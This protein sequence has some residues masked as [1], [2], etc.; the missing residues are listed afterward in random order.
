MAIPK[1]GS[2]KTIIDGN[3]FL[4]K[5]RKHPTHNERHDVDYLIPVQHI[6]GGQVLLLSMGYN[7][8]GYRNDYL[9]MITPGMLA[10]CIKDAISEG[11]NF[12]CKQPPKIKDCSKVLYRRA[13]GLAE[14]FIRLVSYDSG[15]GKQ[16]SDNVCS[17][18][19]AGEYEVALEIA[20]DNI[21]ESEISLTRELI[22]MAREAFAIY[23]NRKYEQI[24]MSLKE[25][26]NDRTR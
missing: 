24:V 21:G 7:R 17:L 12:R 9:F 3:T 8:S 11:W 23:R 14:T 16:I 18:I 2:R 20:I 5:I 4:W 6:E 1:R 15:N 25:K 22:I 10:D 19:N 13:S 26:N